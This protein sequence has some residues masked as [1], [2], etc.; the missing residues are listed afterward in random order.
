ML[1]FQMT[2]ALMP[3]FILLVFAI[4]AIWL[5]AIARRSR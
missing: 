4:V 2:T 5:F 1:T 3:W